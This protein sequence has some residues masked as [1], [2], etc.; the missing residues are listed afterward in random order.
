[1]GCGN[2]GRCLGKGLREA[3]WQI[4][5][6]CC[7]TLVSARKACEFMG[8]GS[9]LE[10][11]EA[12][13]EIAASAP[14]VIVA[15][16]DREIAEAEAVA[17]KQA[18][19]GSVV[20]HLSGALPSSILS[21]CRKKGAGVGSMHPLQSFTDPEAALELLAG[22]IFACEGDE[23]AIAAGFKI[24]ETLGGR[25]LRIE[26]RSKEI[27][28]AAASAASNFM[29]APLM[30]ALDLMEAAGLDRPTGLQALEPLIL[31]TAKNAVKKGAP[32]ALTGPIERN[33]SL[34][35]E[36]HLAAIER[37]CPK[38]KPAYKALARM[39]VEAAR[40]KGKLSDAEVAGLLAI[41]EA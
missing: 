19:T 12:A 34:V 10:L 28:H 1:M 40:R 15:T 22:S 24:A 38:L 8:G 35:I 37:D 36:G 16:P 23:A 7:R 21:E 29:I 2:V 33:D 5:M 3:G 9:P 13:S 11:G 14:L 18:D 41:L 4:A 6:V 25:P 26:T 20:L 27:Y 17:A 39:T 32:D 31:G 30:L